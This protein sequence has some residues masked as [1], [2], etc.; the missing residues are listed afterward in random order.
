MGQSMFVLHAAVALEI[1]AAVAAAFLLIWSM[2]KS[3]AQAK[4]GK[5]VATLGIVLSASSLFCTG[6][7]GLTYWRAGVFAPNAV[8]SVAQGMG[9]TGMMGMHEMMQSM[10]SCAKAG[11]TF[12]RCIETSPQSGAKP[13][14]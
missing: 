7:Y 4:A 12:E 9:M 14:H 2:G 10:H 6:Y 13:G 1:M 8:A 11:D 3:G 5:I